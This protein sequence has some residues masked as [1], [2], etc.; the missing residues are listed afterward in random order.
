MIMLKIVRD[1]PSKSEWK[2]EGNMSYFES[3]N[4]DILAMWTPLGI[5]KWCFNKVILEFDRFDM[6]FIDMYAYFNQKSPRSNGST[7]LGLTRIPK[8][9]ADCFK[10]L[11]A[12]EKISPKADNHNIVLC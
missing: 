8:C 3:P 4:D 1:V 9:Q 2:K 10:R 11:F 6:F 7:D 12:N 5:D